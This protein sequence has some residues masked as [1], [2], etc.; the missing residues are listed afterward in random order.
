MATNTS[1]R[2]GGV[3]TSKPK[4][5]RPK[6]QAT[7]GEPA[8]READRIRRDAEADAARV[9]AEA[10]EHARRL[11]LD[12][13]ASADGVRAEGMELVSNLREMSAVLRSNADRLLQDIQSIHS[14]MVGELE[15]AGP[16]VDA[17]S[18]PS[19]DAVLEVPEF[20]SRG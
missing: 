19:D 20:V 3:G 4:P 15:Q 18:G 12:A 17:P 9:R 2:A 13:R 11:V 16:P 6:R 14:R 10:E 5:H 7:N 8:R 1:S